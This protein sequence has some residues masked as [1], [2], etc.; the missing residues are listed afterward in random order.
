[1]VSR[2]LREPDL[3]RDL[4]LLD[5]LITGLTEVDLDLAVIPMTTWS[6]IIALAC[7][8]APQG[9]QPQEAIYA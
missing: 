1:V 7:R 5:M 2:W 8:P 3:L 6:V 9:G 4:F